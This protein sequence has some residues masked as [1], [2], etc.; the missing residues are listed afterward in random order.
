M[1]VET[2]QKSSNDTQDMCILPYKLN[3]KVIK[4]WTLVDN[5]HSFE[6]NSTE[7]AINFKMHQS[8]DID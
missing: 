6:V 1:G 4:Y 2:H 3:K 7:T 5:I 8:N